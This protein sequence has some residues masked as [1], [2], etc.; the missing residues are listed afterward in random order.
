[1]V[2]SM[3]SQLRLVINNCLLNLCLFKVLQ[4]NAKARREV[5]LH[6]KA[7]GCPY[8]VGIKDV[9]ENKYVKSDCLLVVMEW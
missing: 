9:Y 4:D 5:D 8:I 3:V 7:S 2:K 1:M 6:W